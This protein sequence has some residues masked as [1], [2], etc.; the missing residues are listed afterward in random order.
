MTISFEPTEEQRL[1][2]DTVAQ[3][4]AEKL[5]PRLRETEAA[6]D[7]AAD[8]RSGLA[9]LGI[10][11]LW[12]PEAHGGAGT[13]VRTAVLIEEE[14]GFSDAGA[15]FALPGPNTLAHAL[16]ELGDEAQQTKHFAP[17]AQDPSRVGA[18]AFSE[19]RGLARPGFAATAKREGASWI[20]EGE[21][22]FVLNAGRAGTY[23]VFAQTDEAKGW[24]G[25]GAFV[26][27]AAAKGF[28][29]VRRH[30]T[31]G[32]DAAA[33][34]DVKL[35]GV[36]VEE[37]DRLAG[38]DDFDAA[39]RR[40]FA[41]QSLQV[42]ARAVGVARAGYELA[43]AYADERKAFGKPIAHFQA[44]AF[45]IAD[46]LMDV[47]GARGLVWRAAWTLDGAGSDHWKKKHKGDTELLLRCA[48]SV[49]EATEVAVR[50]GD[51]CIQVH[52]G[53][54]FVRDFIAEKLFRDAK[55]MAL[56]TS[57]ATTSDQLFAA[58]ALGAPLDPAIVLPV[59]EI[60][61]VFI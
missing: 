56:C 58:L 36:R 43:R 47:D 3:F 32:L 46:R 15:A 10:G 38:G 52:G 26:V 19:G 45:L 27:D 16:V 50:C 1:M 28:S 17:F 51:D 39:L 61:P 37:S 44:I 5:R 54:G 22:K 29:V 25:I 53:A 18:V 2:R 23:V 59:P 13:S 8:L 35:E 9:E 57:S 41:R 11:A 33:F 48:E 34:G 6:R 24:N 60:Q 4:G 55:Q 20:L 7:L 42:A 30:Q 21:K 12:T 31:V 40:F 14:L 49:A